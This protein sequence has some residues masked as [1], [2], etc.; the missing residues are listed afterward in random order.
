MSQLKPPRFPKPYADFVM[1]LRVPSGF[2]LAIVFA[3]FAQPSRTS[4]LV[5]AALSLCGLALRAWAAGHLTKN[6]ELTIGG[7]YAYTRNPLYLGTLITA[8]GLAAAAQSWLL[9]AITVLVFVAVYLPVMEQEEQHLV[10]IF[11]GYRAYAEEVP[12]LWPATPKTRPTPKFRFA[13]FL[14]NQ[15]WKAELA[16]LLGQ[17]YL[18]WRLWKT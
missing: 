14:K 17:A 2:L 12:L 7:P 16:W 18:L 11:P 5:G 15:E 8:L 6:Q 1:R 10:N 9:L 3:Y 13:Q 4:L